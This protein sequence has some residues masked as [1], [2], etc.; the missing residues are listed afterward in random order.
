[1]GEPS[2]AF[3]CTDFDVLKIGKKHSDFSI[4]IDVSNYNL[5]KIISESI[6]KFSSDSFSL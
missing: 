5:E 4:H 1:M 6:Q 2:H 3:S